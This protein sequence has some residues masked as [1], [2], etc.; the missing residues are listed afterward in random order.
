M[1][2]RHVERSRD[3]PLRNLNPSPWDLIR[4][5][6]ACSASS[7]PVHVAPAPAAPFSTTLFS[8]RND[9]YETRA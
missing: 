6:P 7:L 2:T 8:A 3:I 5:L 9:I 1:A 4:S